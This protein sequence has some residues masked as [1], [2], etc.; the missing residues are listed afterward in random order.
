MRRVFLWLLLAGVVAI[1]VIAYLVLPGAEYRASA[2]PAAGC[3]APFFVKSARVFDAVQICAT[4]RVGNDKL[5]YAANVVAEWLDNDTDGVLDEPRLRTAFESTNPVLIMSSRQMPFLAMMRLDVGDGVLVQDLWAVE[6]NP[7]NGERDASQEETHHL[8]VN[9]GWAKAFPELFSDTS[10]STM[11]REW[12]K[13]DAGGHY[14]YADPTCNAS[15]KSVEFFY[16][17]TA[18]YL[19]S[20]ADLASDEMRL[21]S[22]VAL[23]QSLPAT[24]SLMT[25]TD[26]TYPTNHWPSGT[27]PHSQNI[28]LNLP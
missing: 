11:Y 6:T 3:P 1:G 28:E 23:Q 12:Q 16:L 14:A 7:Q 2:K 8:I 10:G 17:A 15:C 25:S 21:K 9:A 13:A 19:G 4:T 20:D 26:Y 22:R 24:V 5:S 27:Y 18:A